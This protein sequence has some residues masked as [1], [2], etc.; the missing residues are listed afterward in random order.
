MVRIAIAMAACH[1]CIMMFDCT[2]SMRKV[3]V[4]ISR[5]RAARQTF[6]QKFASLSIPNEPQECRAS[7]IDK[8]Q[9]CT[10]VCSLCL[11]QTSASACEEEEDRVRPR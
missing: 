1:I 7:R 6:L 11:G 4:D 9:E 3:F 10:R 2:N 8:T 5:A